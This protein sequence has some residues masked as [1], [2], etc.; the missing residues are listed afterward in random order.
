MQSQI[1]L[2]AQATRAIRQ[3][4]PM[5]FYDQV[6]KVLVS[7]DEVRIL[8]T[9]FKWRE[10]SREVRFTHRGKRVLQYKAHD[11]KGESG[12]VIYTRWV[13]KED[14]TIWEE[15]FEGYSDD[16]RRRVLT[17][18]EY[19]AKRNFEADCHR[20]GGGRFP[21]DS[22]DR[23]MIQPEGQNEKSTVKMERHWSK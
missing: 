17:P 3:K 22:Y 11:V 14:M 5:G 6:E 16:V 12:V 13:I 4:L 10:M 2:R 15:D 8:L 1:Q 20:P 18:V 23:T 7:D 9:V 19:H 21:M